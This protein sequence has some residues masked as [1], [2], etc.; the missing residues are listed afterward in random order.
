MSV[1]TWLD[2]RARV[3]AD[4]ALQVRLWALPDPAGFR[5]ALTDLGAPAEGPWPWDTGPLRLPGRGAPPVGAP[6][7]GPGWT[8]AT[9]DFAFAH[10]VQTGG[11]APTAPFYGSD[12]LA[13]GARPL[14][15]FLDPRTPLEALAAVAEQPAP[16][17]LIFH[18]SRC[19]ST[20]VGNMLAAAPG[21]LVLS[22]PRAI[23]DGLRRVDLDEAQRAARLRAVVAALR[24]AHGPA[25]H[26]VIKTEAWS[27]VDLAIFRRAFPATPWIF[28][29]RAPV[30]VLASQARLRAP[31]MTFGMS[32][33]PLP[34]IS[35]QEAAG[36][37]PDDYCAQSLGVI[38]AAAVAGLR[39]G[40]GEAIAYDSLPGAV[41]GR[42]A[43]LFGLPEAGE[44][45][46]ER[47]TFDA[48]RPGERF[49]AADAS[50]DPGLQI[51]AAKWINP[52]LA[53]LSGS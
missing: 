36:L 18:M 2:L 52:S 16:D 28:L 31:E 42:I 47:A 51:L 23:G 17:G 40:G 13:W 7:A 26:C 12:L 15:R 50:A 20:L 21:T 10:W 25:A 3:L 6:P 43:P 34:G 44:A 53:T 4:P 49:R 29:H 33:S 41:A 24:A 48:K 30:E 8:I 38:C 46:T 19:G 14:N 11:E 22:E 35:P 37:S 39:Q 27:M 45:M 5:A 1:Q 32:D 9:L